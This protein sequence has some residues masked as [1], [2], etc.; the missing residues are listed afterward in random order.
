MSPETLLSALALRYWG[1]GFNLWRCFSVAWTE[2]T[3]FPLPGTRD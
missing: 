1:R 2:F 3:Y